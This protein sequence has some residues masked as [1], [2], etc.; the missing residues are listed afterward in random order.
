MGK[1]KGSGGR[2]GHAFVDGRQSSA[3]GGQGGDAVIG[4]GGEGGH[5][6][7]VGD[8][9]HAIGGPGGRGG[10]GDGGRGGDAFIAPVD[11]LGPLPDLADPRTTWVALDGELRAAAGPQ[12]AFA[13]G[14]GATVAG[15]QGGEASQADGRGGRGG[16]AYR[17]ISFDGSEVARA[18]MRWPYFEPITEAGRG[19]DAADTPQ[20]KARRLIVE[21]LKRD[22]FAAMGLPL[23]EAWWDRD[24]VPLTWINAQLMSGGHRWRASVVAEEYE[25]AN[26]PR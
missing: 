22:Y 21:S 8:E 16:R 18:H 19:G 13:R 9:S 11:H 24:V 2:G 23:N 14:K 15:G 3:K 17:Q 4:S 10:L 26:L 20:Y 6:V 7:V 12:G 5:A 1:G 25:F